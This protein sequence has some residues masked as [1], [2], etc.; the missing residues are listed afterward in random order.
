MTL[1]RATDMDR[2]S[3]NARR[4]QGG[5]GAFAASEERHDMPFLTAVVIQR[6]C[7][8]DEQRNEAPRAKEAAAR[9]GL[10]HVAA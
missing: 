5:E 3:T 1:R 6:T 8:G 10:L 9:T 4:F 2:Y 7:T